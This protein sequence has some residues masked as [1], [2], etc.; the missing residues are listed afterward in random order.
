[1]VDPLSLTALGA[2]AL[3]QGIAFLYGQASDLLRR[4]RER[5]EAARDPAPLEVPPAAAAAPVL[6]GELAPG[7]VDEDALQEHADQLARL[8]GLLAPYQEGDLPVD[9]TNTQLLEQ[10]AALRALL[11]LV[12]RQHVTFQG[13]S[14]P[15][16]GTA[17]D[18]SPREDATTYAN[19]VIAS[20]ERAVAV[21]RDAHGPIIT[22]NIGSTEPPAEGTR[23]SGRSVSEY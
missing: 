4:R 9:P 1:M 15:P 23:P 11:E 12:Y 7:P 17:L 13:E 14:R 5:A 16:S 8:K 20:G 3:T 18:A 19:Q 2:A 22:G 6:A 10:V 21:G